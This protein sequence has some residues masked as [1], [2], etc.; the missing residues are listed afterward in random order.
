MKYG[1]IV[2]RSKIKVLQKRQNLNK[3]IMGMLAEE[4]CLGK[5]NC[6]ALRRSIFSAF[7]LFVQGNNL[8]LTRNSLNYDHNGRSTMLINNKIY[9]KLCVKETNEKATRLIFIP[10]SFFSSY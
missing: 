1:A 7:G 3:T 9:A 8:Y 6:F 4:N 10:V 2:K 5:E